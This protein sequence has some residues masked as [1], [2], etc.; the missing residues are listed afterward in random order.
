MTVEEADIFVISIND[1][2]NDRVPDDL[3][4]PI[5]LNLRAF[6]LNFLFLKTYHHAFKCFDLLGLQKWRVPT[7]FD[8]VYYHVL[9]QK[10]NVM[11]ANM[12]EEKLE[13]I[14]DKREIYW[15]L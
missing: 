13:E 12:K 15:K 10:W 5:F 11:N 7:V 6:K 4:P 2:I 3:K 1:V 8:G 14:K 9:Q